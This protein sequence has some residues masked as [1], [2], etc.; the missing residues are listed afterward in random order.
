MNT[1]IKEV[2]E[3]GIINANDSLQVVPELV[4]GD[5]IPQGDLNFT[6][7]PGVPTCAIAVENP[8]LQLAPGTTKG[9]RHRLDSL[10]NV[11]V[12]RLPKPNPL[13]GVIL[14]FTGETIVT[15][16][17]HGDQL[18]SKGVVIVSYQRQLADEIRAI[19]D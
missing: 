8:E 4:L 1:T 12:Y 10:E 3:F 17:E 2:K 11:N 14:E 6:L 9:S 15:H 7:L 16:P 5:S 19:A 18:W 13:Q